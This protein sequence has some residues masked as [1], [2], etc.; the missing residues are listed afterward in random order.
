MNKIEKMKVSKNL[1]LGRVIHYIYL[2]R[3]RE[4][5]KANEQTYKIG[6]TK[7]HP[8][9]RLG[10]YA[11]NSEIHFVTSVS[12]CD[13]LEKRML[14]T[15]K[16]LFIHREDLGLEY[17]SGSLHK[18]KNAIHREIN[19]Y[20]DELE[21]MV[22]N[23]DLLNELQ[24][25]ANECELNT[26]CNENVELLELSKFPEEVLELQNLNEHINQR[27]N[28]DC[29]NESEY[30]NQTPQ[31]TDLTSNQNITNN[32]H[33]NSE[34]KIADK[35]QIH[36]PTDLRGARRIPIHKTT[37]AA[38]DTRCFINQLPIVLNVT[39]D[40]DVHRNVNISNVVN[41]NNN[42]VVDNSVNVT[43]SDPSML[44]I[45][46]F[47]RHIIDDKPTWYKEGGIV[48]FD[49]IKQAYREFFSDGSINESVI[50][51]RLNKKIFAAVPRSNGQNVKK[52]Y[53]ISEIKRING[54]L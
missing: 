24:N 7:Q 6:K 52:L 54:L 28:I 39:E 15:F 30:Y 32:S 20:E 18:M 51:R 46:D 11:P 12:N 47:F 33:I 41:N 23:Q 44:T 1:L 29:L 31:Q 49:I 43:T 8:N 5:V 27:D 3:P 19:Q 36:E 22:S 53:K 26:H 35:L 48:S 40:T 25:T 21:L 2:I 34:N 17:F 38:D 13:D 10:Q 50:S 4:F 42:V 45:D 14:A 37:E 9:N 16:K